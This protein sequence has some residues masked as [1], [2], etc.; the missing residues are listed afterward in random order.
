MLSTVWKFQNF[1]DTQN[2]REIKV[3]ESGASKIAILAP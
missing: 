1:S 2:L 3:D